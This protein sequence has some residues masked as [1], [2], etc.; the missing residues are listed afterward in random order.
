MAYS[1]TLKMDVNVFLWNA[2][3]LSV[4]YTVLH[5]KDRT[6]HHQSCENL[7]SYNVLSFTYG[8]SKCHWFTILPA[9]CPFETYLKVSCI[10]QCIFLNLFKS[11]CTL[12]YIFQLILVIIRCLKLLVKTA[13]LSFLWF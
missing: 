1:L 12:H 6:L 7:K 10:T 5:P 8:S 2:I 3:W 11:F 13:V 9:T 4:D